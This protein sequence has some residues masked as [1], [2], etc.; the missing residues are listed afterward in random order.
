MK[1]KPT[2]PAHCA[3]GSGTPVAQCCARFITG[4]AT[5]PDAEALMRSRYTAFTETREDYLL[6]S[7]H[8]DTRP[9]SLDL[10]A[11]AGQKW[12]GL[13]VISHTPIDEHH[14][15]VEFVARYKIGGRACRLHERSR[16]ERLDGRWYYRDG[17]MFDT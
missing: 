15:E 13:S 3:C 11:D 16:F 10:A 1:R 12:L 9:A 2:P 5:P 17:E 4:A 7:W 6:A 8:P 14:A